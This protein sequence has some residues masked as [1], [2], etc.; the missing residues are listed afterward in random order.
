MS[1]EHIPIQFDLFK[2]KEECEIEALR[3]AVDACVDSNGKVRRKL[4]SENGKLGKRMTIL[5]EAQL[6][7][8]M[9]ELESRLA[10]LERNICKG[11]T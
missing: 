5:E 8:K 6:I 10:I 7:Q 11:E 4:F 9:T 2:K 1:A 3:L